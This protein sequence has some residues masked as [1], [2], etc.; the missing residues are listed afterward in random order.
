MSNLQTVLWGKA[1]TTPI[2]N[3]PQAS[4]VSLKI[5]LLQKRTS[6]PPI[7]R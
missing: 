1:S 3:L 4:A 2:Q 5:I 6:L 7:L